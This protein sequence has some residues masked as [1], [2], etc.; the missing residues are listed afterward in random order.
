MFVCLD[1]AVN[2]HFVAVNRVGKRFMIFRQSAIGLCGNGI[3]D[4]ENPL[5]CYQRMRIR[6]VWVYIIQIYTFRNEIKIA[7]NAELCFGKVGCKKR[8]WSLDGLCRGLRQP[9]IQMTKR[10][11]RWR[12]QQRDTWWLTYFAEMH[13]QMR[14]R[15]NLEANRRDAKEFRAV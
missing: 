11:L 2:G 9:M 12:F 8:K 7:T 5:S 4:I 10:R 1:V 15:I 3:F 6:L 13:F 14:P